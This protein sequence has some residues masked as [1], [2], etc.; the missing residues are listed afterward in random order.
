M[1]GSISL[2]AVL[3][4]E[5]RPQEGAG[6]R[7]TRHRSEAGQT[8]II[9]YHHKHPNIDQSQATTETTQQSIRWNC[10]QNQN[11][12]SEG[13]ELPIT[14]Y[15]PKHPNMDQSQSKAKTQATNYNNFFLKTVDEPT[16]SNDYSDMKTEPDYR[17]VKGCVLQLS[18]TILGC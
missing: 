5:D 1:L 2:R 15:N 18:T 17:L 10:T 12:H 4:S 13:K 3:H 14:I 7:C 6:W 8:P 11:R 9:S 16:T